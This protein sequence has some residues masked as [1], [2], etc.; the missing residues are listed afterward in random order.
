ME[1]ILPVDTCL[2]RGASSS[3]QRTRKRWFGYYGNSHDVLKYCKSKQFVSRYGLNG[4]QFY[5]VV[6]AL[7]LLRIPYIQA[8]EFGDVEMLEALQV[9]QL[10]YNYILT[11]NASESPCIARFG[12]EIL[13]QDVY[14]LLLDYLD[15]KDVARVCNPKSELWV[16]YNNAKQAA[17]RYILTARNPDYSFAMLISE[18]GYH[19]WL[20]QA[21]Y[22]QHW[23]GDE[24]FINDIVAMAG[25]ME[26]CAACE[27]IKQCP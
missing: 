21:N 24:L 13:L 27:L 12:S 10:C 6:Q 20:R 5:K 4:F 3:D 8:L 14:A 23:A 26:E 15:P 19:G 22:A 2:I 9:A 1:V 18:L 17:V 11:H 16:F 25:Y 7:A